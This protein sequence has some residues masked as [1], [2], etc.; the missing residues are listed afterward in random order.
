MPA[1]QVKD[2][3]ADLYEDL[4]ACAAEN[5]RSIS[6]QTTSIL[7]SYLA[8]YKRNESGTPSAFAEEGPAQTDCAQCSRTPASFV[9]AHCAPAS[10]APTPRALALSTLASSAPATPMPTEDEARRARIEKRRRLLERIE[11][12]PTFEAPEGFPCTADI[13]RQMRDERPGQPCPV[14]KGL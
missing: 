6:Q 11:S 14:L 12:R 9:P 4:R 13:V 1:L 5:D 10:P 8:A 3:P 7:R 2:F